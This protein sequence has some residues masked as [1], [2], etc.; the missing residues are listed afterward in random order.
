MTLGFI[1]IFF[2]DPVCTNQY[3]L[4]S[5]I[6]SKKKNE[7]DSGCKTKFACQKPVFDRIFKESCLLLRRFANNWSD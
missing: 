3:V 5:K 6:P 2:L 7:F 4:R 1:D